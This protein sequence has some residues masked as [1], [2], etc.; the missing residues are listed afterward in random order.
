MLEHPE[1][2]KGDFL[3]PYLRISGKRHIEL[4][5][6][7]F[8]HGI[9]TLLTPLLGPDIFERGETYRPILEAGLLW[10][11]EDPTFISF[12]ET[13][14]VQVRFY[15]NVKRCLDTPYFRHILDDYRSLEDRTS[16][17]DPLY[18]LFIGICANDATEAVAQIGVDFFSKH[19]RLP[20]K[21]E[22]IEAY[23]GECLAPVSFFI[24][25]DRL[26]AFDM[27]LISTGA[28]DLYF[29]VSPSPYLTETTFR[30]ILYDHLFSRTLNDE[31]Y[32][33]ISRE[34]WKDLRDLYS[35]NFDHVIGVGRQHKSGLF[36]YPL[37]QVTLPQ[38]LEER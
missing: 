1:K 36:W 38:K 25:F 26:S 2:A 14:K 24:G 22:V 12:C 28:E 6:L 27:P 32:S 7:F 37:P 31:E 16:S 9:T 35:E 20:N 29:T 21:N 5:R 17:Y 15:G 19:G 8:E 4:Y 34:D 18:R 10:F 33:N 23:Y 13:K 30:A 3:E 11:V